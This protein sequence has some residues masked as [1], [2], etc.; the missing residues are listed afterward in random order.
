MSRAGAHYRLSRLYRPRDGR[1][2][3]M[4]VLNLLSAVLA[5]VLRTYPL[6]PLAM[7]VIALFA[8]GN[9]LLG[10][11]L[12]ID[13]MRAPPGESPCTDELDKDARN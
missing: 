11:R 13:L 5:W 2:W 10:M 7:A 4:I 12:M 8:L 1:F 3:L 6:V 9:A